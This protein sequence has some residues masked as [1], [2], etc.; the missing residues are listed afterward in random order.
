M[1]LLR[2]FFRWSAARSEAT[3]QFRSEVELVV[4]AGA[5]QAI[6]QAD[7]DRD[8]STRRRACLGAKISVEVFDFCGPVVSEGGFDASTDGP[9]DLCISIGDARVCKLLIAEDA[10]GRTIK[11]NPIRRETESPADR[12]QP[13]IPRLA[14]TGSTAD[15]GDGTT[16]DAG[17]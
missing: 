8:A 14:I 16:V 5:Y 6:G 3:L 10:A 9:A 12:A 17:I 4:D 7:G 2:R 11:Q 1:A 15:G 13:G